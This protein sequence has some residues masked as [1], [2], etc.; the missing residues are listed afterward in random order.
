MREAIRRTWLN[1]DSWKFAENLI[2]HRVF[3]IGVDKNHTKL[4]V[5]ADTCKAYLLRHYLIFYNL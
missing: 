4:N 3:L 2:I 1:Q 5:E